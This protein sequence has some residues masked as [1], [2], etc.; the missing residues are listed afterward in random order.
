MTAPT[1][2]AYPNIRAYLERENKVVTGRGVGM[3]GVVAA[4]AKVSEGELREIVEDGKEI[5]DDIANAIALVVEPEHDQWS[6]DPDDPHFN[7]HPDLSNDE[8]VKR[9][10]HARAEGVLGV[11]ANVSGVKGGVDALDTICDRGGRLDPVTRS[12]LLNVMTDEGIDDE[13]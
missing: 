3:L 1:E 11:I 10:R 7:D 8:I 6:L 2:G 4:R 9:L 13:G 12:L 5:S